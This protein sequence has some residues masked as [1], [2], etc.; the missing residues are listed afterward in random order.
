MDI[1]QRDIRIKGNKASQEGKRL[2]RFL[3]YEVYQS[4]KFTVIKE[5]EIRQLPYCEGQEMGSYCLRGEK[6]FYQNC[7]HNWTT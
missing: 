7:L 5:M 4:V 6:G 1:P 2:S 3:F